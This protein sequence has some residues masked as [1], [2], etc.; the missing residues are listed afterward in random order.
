MHEVQLYVAIEATIF[1]IVRRAIEA[2]VSNPFSPPFIG[3]D[4]AKVWN[5][6]EYSK[7]FAHFFLFHLD[8]GMI[9]VIYDFESGNCLKKLQL[10]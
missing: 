5:L 8:N 2:H 1:R 7:D 9:V 3:M 10:N 4:A 6:V